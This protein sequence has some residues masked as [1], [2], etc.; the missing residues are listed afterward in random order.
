MQPATNGA[1]AVAIEGDRMTALEI[2]GDDNEA[3]IISLCSDSYVREEAK[4]A[5]IAGLV[6]RP[7]SAGVAGSR[8]ADL[9]TFKSGAAG[10][11]K[12]RRGR[13]LQ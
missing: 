4:P 10:S 5:G 12:G 2:T 9:S 7:A 8:P 13:R 6:A 1:V 11:A 3:G